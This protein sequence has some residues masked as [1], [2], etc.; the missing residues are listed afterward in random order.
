MLAPDFLP[1]AANC[2]SFAS[3]SFSYKTSLIQGGKLNKSTILEHLATLK[4]LLSRNPLS[5]DMEDLC[6]KIFEIH[7][8]IQL[9][10]AKRDPG[11]A[12][13][14]NVG[15]APFHSQ[16]MHMLRQRDVDVFISLKVSPL[17][18]RWGLPGYSATN[19]LECSIEKWPVT[20][21]L[22]LCLVGLEEQ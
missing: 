20:F 14:S 10:I 12:V 13:V 4:L 9:E 15:Y 6:V 17:E 22:P 11:F 2:S 8:D 7:A 3:F 21:S 1:S 18:H 16:L 5:K 19:F